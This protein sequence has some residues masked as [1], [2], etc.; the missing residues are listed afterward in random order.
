MTID[1]AT[2]TQSIKPSA[3]L[4]ISAKANELRAQGKDIINLSVGEPDFD[5]PDHI[6]MAAKQAITDGF[7]K[8]TAVDGIAELKEAI[9]TKFK[10]DNQLT[11]TPKHILV[12]NGAK[13]S[14]FNLMFSLLNPGDEV[15]IPSPYWVS[16][17]SMVALAEGTPITL[18]TGIHTHFKITPAQLEEH[19]TDKTKL[20]V[21]NNP[22]NPTG[23]TYTK[24][25]LAALGDVLAAHPNIVIVSDDIYEHI[26]WNNTP[27]SNIL[28]THPALYDR[29]VIVNGVSKAY[30]MTGW[31]IGYAAGP[32]ELIAM[33]KKIQSQST[34]NP[35]AIAQKAAVAALSEDQTCVK[36]MLDAFKA[37]HDFVYNTFQSIP[38]FSCLPGDGAFYLFPQVTEAMAM[39]NCEDDIQLVERLLDAGVATV[40]GSAFGAPGHIRISYAAHQDLLAEALNRIKRLL[41]TQTK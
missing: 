6:K 2:R 26:L 38:G 17:P 30:A 16:Y 13:H 36:I 25:E 23:L 29:T 34:S 10:R 7:T 12:S 9:V 35:N 24:T 5:T 41:E 27:F 21:L 18:T 20:L 39:L 8:Y 3:T 22:S 32:A 19:I 11:Y 33:M 28:N 37:R 40:P 15:L 4:A 1:L 14:L 31:R